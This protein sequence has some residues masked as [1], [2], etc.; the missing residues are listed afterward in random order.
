MSCNAKIA[1]WND[2]VNIWIFAKFVAGFATALTSIVIAFQRALALFIPTVAVVVNRAATPCRIIG[3]TLIF[4]HPT[5]LAFF[6]AKA[7]CLRFAHNHLIGLATIRALFRLA[8]LA[9]FAAAKF[10]FA[11]FNPS[12]GRG[13]GFAA[14]LTDNFNARIFGWGCFGY[15]LGSVT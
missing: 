2:M 10:R 9:A 3:A 15:G 12:M 14:T 5:K 7:A 4:T 6:G 13:E 8:I 1:E 11:A